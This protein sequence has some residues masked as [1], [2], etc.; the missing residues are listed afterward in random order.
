M[1]FNQQISLENEK[2]RIRNK[3]LEDLIE[4]LKNFERTNL[5]IDLKQ[6]V[7]KNYKRFSMLLD[8]IYSLKSQLENE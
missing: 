4:N 5:V 6:F 2:L 3:Y 8:E 7:V 1:N